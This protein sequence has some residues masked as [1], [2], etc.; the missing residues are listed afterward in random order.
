MNL[1]TAVESKNENDL[2]QCLDH[3]CSSQIDINQFYYI[4][5]A[6]EETWHSQ[7]EDI[8][9]TI[10]LNNFKDDIFV[11]PILQIALNKE[12]FRYFDDELESTLRKCIH[13]L[14][15][16]NS[17]NSKAALK[18]LERSNN[19]NVKFVLEMYK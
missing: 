17:I 1:K 16:I 10:Y 15:S 19:E 14:I 4:K 13:A 18:I 3:K 2:I 9:N 5:K 11:E 6:L 8:V 7:H 12:K